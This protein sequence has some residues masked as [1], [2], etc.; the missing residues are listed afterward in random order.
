MSE[1]LIAETLAA[2]IPRHASRP[3]SPTHSLA[4]E[5]AQ[6]LRNRINQVDNDITELRGDVHN[7]KTQISGNS[8]NIAHLD[9]NITKVEERLNKKLNK[10]LLTLSRHDKPKP[11]MEMVGNPPPNPATDGDPIVISE[12]MKEPTVE[13]QTPQEVPVV[14]ISQT[15]QPIIGVPVPEGIPTATAIVTEAENSCLS[16][17]VQEP[18]RQF[19]PIFSGTKPP[20]PLT[21]TVTTDTKGK[22]G[23]IDPGQ[24]AGSLTAGESVTL[25]P[26]F[27]PGCQGCIRGREG[28]A[29]R[30]SRG[31]ERACVL[32]GLVRDDGPWPLRLKW[33]L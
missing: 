9:R 33:E 8:N 13:A 21:A 14:P 2:Y 23:E 22:G 10:I 5:M 19:V 7:M 18:D 25:P 26:H 3:P 30:P 27:R 16:I 31:V 1:A 6:I 17:E 15:G 20:T 11:C 28:L 29:L 24:L 4:S 12:Q 32:T